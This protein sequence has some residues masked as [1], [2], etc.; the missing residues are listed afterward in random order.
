M[1]RANI[2]LKIA[3]G[4]LLAFFCLTAIGVNSYFSIVQLNSENRTSE[5]SHTA[6]LTLE[7]L[8]SALVNAE[9]GVRGY[10]LSGQDGYLQPYLQ[11]QNNVPAQIAELSTL[12]RN[13]PSQRQHLTILRELYGQELQ[14]WSSTISIRR[15]QGLSAALPLVASGKSKDLMDA[16]R[17]QIHDMQSAEGAQVI[18][19]DQTIRDLTA[20]NKQIILWGTLLTAL[21]VAVVGF[22]IQ[23][24]IS[25]P[26]QEVTE[27]AE[28]IARGNLDIHLTATQRSDEVGEMAR[29][30]AQMS[31]FLRALARQAERIGNGDLTGGITVHDENDML[32]AAFANMSRQ[33]LQMTMRLKESAAVLSSSVRQILAAVHEVNSGVTETAASISQ[34]TATVEEVRQTASLSSQKAR[35]V[36]DIAQTSMDISAQGKNSVEETVAGMERI[37]QQMEAIAASI[38]RMSEHGQA[39]GEIIAVVNDLAEQSNLLAVNAAIE[40]ARAGEHGKGFAV[41]AQEVRSLADQSRQATAQ[42]RTILN[43]IQKST[44]VAVM[45]AEQGSRTVEAGLR[46]AAHS[47][48]AMQ[49]LTASITDASR[50]AVQIAASSQ[51]QLVGMDQ[52]AEAV[53]SVKLASVQNV[54]S[55]HQVQ[56]AAQHLEKTGEEL[57]RLVQRYRTAAGASA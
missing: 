6:E 41:V 5:N 44:S 35:T 32:G 7:R 24:N 18:A 50:A 22:L 52:I 23:R 56:T 9:T 11:Q 12:L 40:A 8:L 26:L 13:V 57:A 3:L 38:V 49:Q 33:L 51:Q 31:E 39:I 2:G 21:L 16:M 37:R 14:N 36:S 15:S 54:N 28:K 17:T 47:G 45:A 1:I 55:V 30:F 19:G 29:S 25:A 43:E 53:E 46:Q 42:V 10:V 27:A 20:R 4:F 34:T 48:D